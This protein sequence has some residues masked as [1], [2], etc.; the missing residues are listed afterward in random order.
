MNPPGYKIGRSYA[1]LFQKTFFQA[2]DELQL[3]GFFVVHNPPKTKS[4]A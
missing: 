2:S 1:A 3:S 4:A